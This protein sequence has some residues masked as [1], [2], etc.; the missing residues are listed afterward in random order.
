MALHLLPIKLIKIVIEELE[1]KFHY[2]IVAFCYTV[3]LLTYLP[4]INHKQRRDV[5]D[6]LKVYV[7]NLQFDFTNTK[8]TKSPQCTIL[9][10]HESN[11]SSYLNRFHVHFKPEVMKHMKEF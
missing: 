4:S 3:W 7:H 1:K 2:S 5:C 10:R 9:L 8:I 11:L 6:F